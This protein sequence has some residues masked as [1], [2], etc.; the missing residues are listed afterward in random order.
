MIREAVTHNYTKTTVVTQISK[1]N[2]DAD[3]SEFLKANSY[4]GLEIFHMNIKSKP[5]NSV[6]PTLETLRAHR[7]DFTS[8]SY[9]DT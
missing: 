5:L 8:D 3:H 4:K 2:V 7:S 6:R 9:S 1:S